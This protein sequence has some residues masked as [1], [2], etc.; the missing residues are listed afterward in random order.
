MNY[1]EQLP[2]F[3][4]YIKL[5]QWTAVENKNWHVFEKTHA[6]EVY[7]IVLPKRASSDSILYLE[8]AVG[9]LA[10]FEDESEKLTHERVQYVRKDLLKVRNLE[11]SEELSMS[12]NVASS[13]I[14]NISK[15]VADAAASD[16]SPKPFRDGRLPAVSK[17]MKEHCRFGHTFV[18]SFGYRIE[19]EVIREEEQL[20]FNEDDGFELISPVERRVMERVVRGL[21]HTENANKQKSITPLLSGYM[22]GFNANMC[23]ALKRIALNGTS[24][25]EFRMLWSPKVSVDS[26]LLI[27]EGITITEDHTH[28][29][30]SAYE[31]LKAVEP[32]QVTIQGHILGVSTKSA[33]MGSDTNRFAMIRWDNHQ[34]NTDKPPVVML[35]L[36]K[37]NYLEANSAHL[38]WKPVKVSGTL[39]ELGGK[40][41]LYDL[42]EFSLI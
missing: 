5:K 9:V 20:K 35:T 25:V 29:I 32:R 19:S 2:N 15:L 37:Q 1:S 4:Q 39:Q 11:T 40:R 22:D 31:E 38:D 42:T 18:G 28:Y 24:A 3:Q 13:Q 21:I 7:E 10:G 30:D 6:D 41:K 27:P 34:E 36:D 17:R 16:R 14:N 23:Q 26:R 33:P 8:K 12:L